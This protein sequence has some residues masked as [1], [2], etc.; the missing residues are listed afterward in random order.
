MT[1]L[2][3]RLGTPGRIADG[4]SADGLNYRAWRA[5]N[6]TAAWNMAMTCFDRR[7]LVGYRCWLRRAAKAGNQEAVES[8][9]CFETRL[10]H[11]TARDIGRHRP[12]LPRDGFWDERRL[13]RRRAA[14]R[15]DR[16]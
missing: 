14:M 6:E 8:L 1:E 11:R 4:W 12:D 13:Q 7:D 15:A 9:P 10:P 16:R 2:S 3:D 5:G